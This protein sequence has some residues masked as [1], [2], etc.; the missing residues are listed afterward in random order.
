[1]TSGFSVRVFLDLLQESYLA[2]KGAEAGQT[3]R[4]WNL[5]QVH[6]G[7]PDIHFEV[8]PQRKTNRLELGLHFEGEQADSYAWAERLSA[9]AGIALTELGPAA[10]ME[11]WTASWT[12]LHETWPIGVLDHELAETVAE[13]LALYV[14]T[15]CPLLEAAE[16]PYRQP[17]TRKKATTARRYR[18]R[19]TKRTL[20]S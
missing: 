15:L 1:M 8:W 12:R 6:F 10:E 20:V 9:Y 16:I 13:R 14:E 4:V 17:T 7:N 3:K 19:S 18:Q 2:R 5:L 11:E